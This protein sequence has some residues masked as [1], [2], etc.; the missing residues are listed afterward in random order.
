MFTTFKDFY[1]HLSTSVHEITARSGRHAFLHR[2]RVAREQ[3][4][5]EAFRHLRNELIQVWYMHLDREERTKREMG[6]RLARMLE[7]DC[8]PASEWQ[9]EEEEEGRHVYSGAAQQCQGGMSCAS[10]SSDV[11]LNADKMVHEGIPMTGN[12]DPSK[13][14]GAHVADGLV[15]CGT[16]ALSATY[17]MVPAM[18]S[19]R[20]AAARAQ[21]DLHRKLDRQE[22]SQGRERARRRMAQKQMA[23]SSP[24]VAAQQL[25]PTTVSSTDCTNYYVAFDSTTRTYVDV[26]AAGPSTKRRRVDSGAREEV[27]DSSTSEEIKTNGVTHTTMNE[28]DHDEEKYTGKGKGRLGMGMETK[29][30]YVRLCK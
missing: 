20:D 14:A 27:L 15:R 2:A 3:E 13:Q 28:S 30:R 5:V 23:S 6:E 7:G 26:D 22:L 16:A 29:N 19:R 12:L 11:L 10:G 21:R 17:G 4:D 25:S 1:T 9:E 8:Y 18:A 24:A